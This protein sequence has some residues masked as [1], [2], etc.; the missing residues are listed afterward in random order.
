MILKALL[1]KKCRIGRMTAMNNLT[2]KQTPSLIVAVLGHSIT[3]R[4]GIYPRKFGRP[5]RPLIAYE[6]RRPYTCGGCG[7][8]M[9]NGKECH[10][11]E[12]A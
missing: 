9:Y 6:R 3:K 12:S 1:T 11:E 7:T 8:R 5:T 2:S 10:C 4:C